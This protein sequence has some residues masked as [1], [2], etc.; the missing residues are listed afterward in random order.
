[1]MQ[2]LWCFKAGEELCAEGLDMRTKEDSSVKSSTEE[3]GIGV[4]CKGRPVKVSWG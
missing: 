2:R 3:L 4:K 1:M